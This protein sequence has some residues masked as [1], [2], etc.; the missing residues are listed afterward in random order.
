[1]TIKKDQIDENEE[2]QQSELV[3]SQDV[4]AGESRR[5]FTRAGLAASGVV[6]TLASAPVLG[7]TA[8]SP[9]GFASGN[10]SHSGNTQS[11]ACSPCYWCSKETWGHGIKRDSSSTKNDGTKFRVLFP[12]C[13]SGS[14][15]YSSTCSDLI[16]G[17]S[18]DSANGYLGMYL[19]AAYLNS[20]SGWTSFLPPAKIQQMFTEWQSHGYFSPS[21][22]VQ[23]NATK[24]VTY[25]KST[26]F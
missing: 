18:F 19:V 5:R 15:Y 6:F 25:L 3:T 20:I 24:I 10:L 13:S 21:P 1:M 4:F 14:K 2:N 23:W 7:C 17:Q 11:D 26:W 12:T 22:G 16:E 8:Q 9:S